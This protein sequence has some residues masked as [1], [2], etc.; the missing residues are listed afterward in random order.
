QRYAGA[1]DL[2]EDLRRFRAG[3]PI[4]A[5]PVGPLE[6]GWRWCRRNPAVAS[7]GA[8]VAVSLLLGAAVAG[9]FAVAAPADADRGDREAQDAR[10][11]AEAEARAKRAAFANAQ[12]AQKETARARQSEFTTLHNLYLSQMNQASLSWQ[13]GQVG[14]VRELLDAQ[15]PQRTGGHD[16]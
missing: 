10:A 3:E 1:A 9:W 8:A 14:R 4:Q 15:R 12:R 11:K 5:R 16:F 13:A 2:A 6:R 7:L